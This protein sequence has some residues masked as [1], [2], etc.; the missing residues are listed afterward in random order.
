LNHPSPSSSDRPRPAGST[1]ASRSPAY[2]PDIDGLRAVAVLAVVAFHAFPDWVPGGFVGVDVFFVISGYLISTVILDN[3]ARDTFSFRTFYAR[4]IRRIFPALLIVLAAVYGIGWFVLFAV[5]F[6]QLGG[7]IAAGAGFVSNLVLWNES[8]YFDSLAETKPLLHVWSL[9]IEEQFYLLWPWLLWAVAKRRM[10]PLRV[11]GVLAVASFA[12]SIYALR[13]D[14]VAAFFLPQNRAW[15]LLLGALLAQ[16]ALSSQ[17][18]ESPRGRRQDVQALC[19][20][21]LIALALGFTVRN[22]FPG[23]W[24]LLPTVG[25]ALVINAGPAAWLNR[26]V[27]SRGLIVWVGLIS[28]PLYLWHWPLLSFG[29]VALGDVPGVTYRVGAI[30]VAI[31]LAWVTYRAIERPVRF[32]RPSNAKVAVLT[33]CMLVVGFFGYNCY[34][35]D[36]LGYR[37]IEKHVAA[38]GFDGGDLGLSID[39]CGIADRSRQR[40][41]AHCKRDSRS[42]A[43]IA[44]V[45]DSKAAALYD[46][47]VRTSL[48]DRRWLFIG[49]TG[50]GGST[51]PVLSSAPVYLPHQRLVKE[52]FAAVVANKAID[53]VV[54]VTGV[55]SLFKLPND[56]SIEE[57]P[58]SGLGDVVLDGLERA[59]RQLVASGRRVVLVVDNPTLPDPKECMSRQTMFAWLTRAIDTPVRK[60]CVMP[61]ARHLALSAKYRDVLHQIRADI[62]EHVD[63]FD[64]TPYLCDV[65]GGICST[66]K[67]KDLLYSFTDHISDYAAGIIGKDLNRVVAVPSN[68]G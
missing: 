9:S 50:N 39:E 23:W 47:L 4:R 66:Y 58:S 38:I 45:G 25:T 35:R 36:G 18:S 12:L 32:G 28:Y 37:Y 30:A 49:G 34:R 21:A 10:N 53:T 65:E 67:G 15:E 51:V 16:H 64:T 3:I 31:A 42:P 1:D 57:L 44:L 60:R 7:H 2:R 6:K 48:D 56:Y 27:L 59:V 26:F 24:A 14:A 40:W 62:P 41:F 68:G 5:E 29:R 54:L 63:L 33:A 55:R 46:G 11:T 8:G 17:T 19:G 20:I 52:A 22:E 13:Q 61:L 43:R